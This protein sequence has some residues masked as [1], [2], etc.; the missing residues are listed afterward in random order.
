MRKLVVLALVLV[1]VGGCKKK[2]T[3]NTSGNTG[4]G[5]SGGLNSGGSGG[6][7]QG[8]RMAAGR[9]VSEHELKNIHLFIETASGASGQMPTVPQIT[10]ALQKEAPKTYQLVQEGAIVLTGAT[11]RE[12]IWA[13]TAKPQSIA[14]YHLALSSSGIEKLYPQEL[15]RRLGKKLGQ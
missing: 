9:V 12:S 14:G 4:G 6:A 15:E 1:L 11:T 3:S 2:P 5:G 7:V 8:V 10:A 13:Y